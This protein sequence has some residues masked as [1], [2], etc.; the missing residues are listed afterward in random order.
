MLCPLGPLLANMFM[1]SL[2]HKML[3]K[4]RSCLCNWRR[5][6]D[7]FVYVLPSKMYSIIRKLNPYHLDTMF[8]FELE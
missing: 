2:E 3:S 4:L 8:T 7:I 1:V 6:D 5:L